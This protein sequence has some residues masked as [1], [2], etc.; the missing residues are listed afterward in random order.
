[1]VSHGFPPRVALRQ[2]KEG[3]SKGSIFGRGSALGET[4]T[5]MDFST[6]TSS[7]RVCHFATSAGRVRIKPSFDLSLKLTRRFSGGKRPSPSTFVVHDRAEPLSCGM[8]ATSPLSARS[9]HAG[10][11]EASLVADSLALA[12]H[13]IYDQEEIREKFGHV[14]ELEAPPLDGYHAGKARGAQTH[15]GDQTLVLM[16]SLEACGGN[17]VM[18]DFARRWARILEGIK[19]LSRPRHEGDAGPSRGRPRIDARR[20]ALDRAGRPGPHR[21]ASS[22]ATS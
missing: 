6:R 2:E 4:R 12:P 1:M 15:Y 10:L 17:F 5:P 11:L 20:L 3:G 16:E 19:G 14:S 22:G 8:T 21:T 9:R 18:D 13:W 7:V